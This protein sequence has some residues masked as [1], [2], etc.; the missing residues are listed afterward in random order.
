MHIRLICASIKFTYLL[1]LAGY[2][3]VFQR[4]KYSRIVSLSCGHGF[5]AGRPNCTL[6]LGRTAVFA[7]HDF[8]RQLLRS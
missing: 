1:T 2:Q 4:T 7:S 8:M 3:S 5:A 6:L